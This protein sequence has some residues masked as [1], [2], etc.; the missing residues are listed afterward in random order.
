MFFQRADGTTYY[1]YN[2]KNVTEFFAGNFS[3]QSRLWYDPIGSCWRFP[4]TYDST[5]RVVEDLPEDP[6]PSKFMD[7]ALS[8]DYRP[9]DEKS[10]PC[11]PKNSPAALP[12]D[13]DMEQ[14][15]DDDSNPTPR[16]PSNRPTALPDDDED[17]G[18][19]I[20]ELPVPSLR[21]SPRKSHPVDRFTSFQTAATALRSSPSKPLSCK[22]S[23]HKP[24]SSRASGSMVVRSPKKP[25]ASEDP[26]PVASKTEVRYRFCISSPRQ[27]D[28]A[29]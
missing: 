2:E 23:R 12:D 22:A 15:Q 24:P 13:E 19:D 4:L 29:H 21:R 20:G 3:Q 1:V 16:T 28:H 7:G 17:D 11:T 9:K 25:R 8:E 10:V 27:S 26:F 5:G 14:D 18:M 6:L